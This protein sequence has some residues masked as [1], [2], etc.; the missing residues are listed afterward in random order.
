M[1]ALTDRE[2]DEIDFGVRV[3]LRSALDKLRELEAAENVRVEREAH[4]S[5]AAPALVRWLGG[6]GDG[7]GDEGGR[8]TSEHTLAAH[9]KGVTLFLT[10]SLKRVSDAQ[11]ALQEQRVER[12]R[13]RTSTLAD[14]AAATVATT[15]KAAAHSTSSNG[16][17]LANSSYKLPIP[18]T[19][20]DDDD[21]PPLESVLTPAQVQQFEQ[22]ESAM[23]RAAQTDLAAIEHAERSLVE[24]AHLQTQLARELAAQTDKVDALYGDAIA[25][26][27]KVGDANVQLRQAR[28]RNRESRTS[29]IVFIMIASF[30]ILFL[31]FYAD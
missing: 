1:R 3:A 30:A 25:T 15:A 11:R 6:H 29:I 2:R 19:A 12:E 26:A 4:R 31:D 8:G 10:G 27:G 23:L 16:G 17:V 28:E 14:S 13:A 9:R 22:E 7:D 24:I 5:S 21:E 20:A 18:Q